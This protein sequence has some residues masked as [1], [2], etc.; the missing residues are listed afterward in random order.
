MR[1]GGSIFLFVALFMAE[2]MMSTAQYDYTDFYTDIQGTFSPLINLL[3]P[4]STGCLV[5]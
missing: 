2:I 5:H 3:Y 4:D 1:F